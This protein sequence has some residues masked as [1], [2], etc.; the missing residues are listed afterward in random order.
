QPLGEIIALAP[1][2]VNSN[3]EYG[4]IS[5][6]SDHTIEFVCQNED[7]DELLR[8]VFDSAFSSTI[9]VD[10]FDLNSEYLCCILNPIYGDQETTI[11]PGKV[12]NEQ[13][14]FELDTD[15]EFIP[16]SENHFINSEYS[17]FYNTDSSKFIFHNN[18]IY[19]GPNADTTLTANPTLVTFDNTLNTNKKNSPFQNMIDSAGKVVRPI[20][21][22]IL[23]HNKFGIVGVGQFTNGNSTPRKVTQFITQIH[24]TTLDIIDIWIND[25][26]RAF[27]HV[28]AI[29]D[30]LFALD[31]PV[32]FP[33][34]FNLVE[35]EFNEIT[36]VQNQKA[37]Y[38]NFEVYPNPTKGVLTIKG[39]TRLIGQ[40]YII[41]SATGATVMSGLLNHQINVN[42]LSKG[43]YILSIENG[44]NSIFIKE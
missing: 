9:K 21:N 36:S 42:Q 14:I 4:H 35:L 17:V 13:G 26:A 38:R 15:L 31:V 43:L 18:L 37:P 3:K 1:I 6:K 11:F 32:G 24:P 40:D 33:S 39:E 2:Q 34:G 8:Y 22:D 25:T 10:T 7:T 20:L 41:Y 12:N 28:E 16:F 5:Y 19:H 29:D 27:R 30:K 44:Q 23:V